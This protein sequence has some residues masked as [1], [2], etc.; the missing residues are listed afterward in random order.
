MGEGAS[1]IHAAAKKGHVQIVKALLEA[2]G[3]LD[4]GAVYHGLMQ[5]DAALDGLITNQDKWFAA[6]L[7]TRERGRTLDLVADS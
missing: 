5:D 7:L 3:K 6:R 2:G 1:A 4:A